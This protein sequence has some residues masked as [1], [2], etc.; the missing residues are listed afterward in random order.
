MTETL[1]QVQSEVRFM[2][3]SG[4]TNK[5]FIKPNSQATSKISRF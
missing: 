3:H 2:M 1:K 4:Y 5:I